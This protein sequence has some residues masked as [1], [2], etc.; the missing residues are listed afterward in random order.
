MVWPL[1]PLPQDIDIRDIAHALSNECRYNGMCKHH[2]SVAQHCLLVSQSV[3]P[4]FALLG[5]MHD[6]SEAFLKDILR[7]IK[8]WSGMKEY[9]V[10]EERMHKCIAEALGFTAEIPAEVK[11]ADTAMLGTERKALMAP[12]PQPWIETVPAAD[13]II[14]RMTPEGAEA[15]FLIRYC[16]LTGIAMPEV[17]EWAR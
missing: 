16:K 17:P 11:L 5:L 12:P 4:E 9:L 10:V 3:P 13:V 8:R 15:E 7:P 1:N 14:H 6:S 2:Y